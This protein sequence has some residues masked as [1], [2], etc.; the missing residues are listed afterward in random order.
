MNVVE[1]SVPTGFRT[2]RKTQT[3]CAKIDTLETEEPDKKCM[4]KN[5]IKTLR[6]GKK[7]DVYRYTRV[8]CRFFRRKSTDF[9]EPE[10]SD[11]DC[12]ILPEGHQYLFSDK[13]TQSNIEDERGE[14]MRQ[15]E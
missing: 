5:K 7:Q 13:I 2:S 15:V 3:S 14:K 9:L 4:K 10:E 11:K 1:I 8:L 6:C 12:I